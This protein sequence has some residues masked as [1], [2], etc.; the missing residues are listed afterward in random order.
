MLEI[1]KTKDKT[2][3]PTE[4]DKKGTAKLQS[5]YKQHQTEIGHAEAKLWTQRK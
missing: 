1:I 4:M 2:R 5:F 3:K